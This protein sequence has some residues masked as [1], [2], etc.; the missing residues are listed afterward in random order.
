MV[1]PEPPENQTPAP[2]VMA[3]TL[4]GFAVWRTAGPVFGGFADP[5][6]GCRS[7]DIIDWKEIP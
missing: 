3:R 2:G 6:P 7:V 4:P 5:G 1:T